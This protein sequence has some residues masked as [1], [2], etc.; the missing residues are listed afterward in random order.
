MAIARRFVLMNASCTK[1]GE[2]YTLYCACLSSQ[3]RLVI[4]Y[5]RDGN[6][7]I[8]A[9][10]QGKMYVHTN[11]RRSYGTG[12][13]SSWRPDQESP[14]C[15]HDPPRFHTVPDRHSKAHTTDISQLHIYTQRVTNRWTTDIQLN[16][17]NNIRIHMKRWT[18]QSQQQ[19]TIIWM[20][21]KSRVTFSLV[22][23]VKCPRNG[24]DGVT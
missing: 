17:S 10:Y 18:S 1:N 15:W 3:L 20:S 12:L 19:L 8:S 23:F 6:F 9:Q 22:D 16:N 13:A 7:K 11:L 21:D 5:Q 2:N 24:C 14:S 4:P